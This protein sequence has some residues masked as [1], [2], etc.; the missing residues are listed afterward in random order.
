MKRVD[1]T[2]EQ[3]QDV[4][5]QRRAG[6]SWVKVE[7]ATGVSRRVAQRAYREWEKARSI[8]ELEN[9]RVKVGEIEFEGHVNDLARA[10]RYFID[11]RVVPDY[12]SFPRDADKHI[13]SLMEMEIIVIPAEA[14]SEASEARLKARNKRRNQ[15]LLDALKQHTADI[16]DWRSLDDW[17][18]G[19]NTCHRV[20]PGVKNLI[21][22]KVNATFGRF[23][24]IDSWFDFKKGEH[25]KPLDIIKWGI[26]DALWQGI[27][28]GNVAAATAV[29]S[30]K[31][32]ELAGSEALQITIG[33]RNLDQKEKRDA[34]PSLV[35]LCHDV[36]YD[37][38]ESGEVQEVAAA[39]KKMRSV[40]DEME[41]VLEPL[42]LRPQILRTR[43]KLCPA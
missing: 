16:F 7:R 19:W 25:N 17:K 13:E 39:V 41:A 42:V 26:K 37:L 8:R 30:S 28:A 18:E 15:L 11:H 3:L 9:V 32:I 38:W 1:L 27:V 22:E 10:A 2:D 33:K 29:I 5:R 6:L 40:V 14:G 36:I 12:P 24:D 4:I 43:C 20:F 35:D 34:V 31:S 23:P 21:S